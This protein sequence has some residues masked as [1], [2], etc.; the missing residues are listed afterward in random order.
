MLFVLIPKLPP[1]YVLLV[2]LR[3]HKESAS[4]DDVQTNEEVRN[5]SDAAISST[6][7]KRVYT[8]SRAQIFAVATVNLIAEAICVLPIWVLARHIAMP[9]LARSVLLRTNV[10]PRTFDILPR[11]SA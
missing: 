6:V 4:G 7:R 8:R 10:R 3:Q 1:Q 11:P 2:H 5:I 9:A